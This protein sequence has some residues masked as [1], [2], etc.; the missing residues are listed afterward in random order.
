MMRFCTLL[1]IFTLCDISLSALRLQSSGVYLALGGPD[2][3]SAILLFF[4][5]TL[6][7]AG[8]LLLARDFDAGLALIA[9]GIIFVAKP[10]FEAFRY[11]RSHFHPGF[12]T[13][14][15]SGHRRSPHLRVVRSDE[16]K[17]TIH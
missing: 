17:P 5:T 11:L 12:E 2:V 7:Y 9:A 4:G 14:K 8:D 3:I 16:E 6:A 13:I 15:R 10:S 1:L